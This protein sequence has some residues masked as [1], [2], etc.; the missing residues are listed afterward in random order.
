MA[1]P[2][3]LSPPSLYCGYDSKRCQQVEPQLAR[4]PAPKYTSPP[5]FLSFLLSAVIQLPVCTSTRLSACCR[6]QRQT[7]FIRSALA[8]P[9]WP[10]NI[11]YWSSG[12]F[13]NEI[14]FNDDWTTYVC[15]SLP[16]S[17]SVFACLS[18]SLAF[19]V[20]LSLFV[21]VS[22]VMGSDSVSVSGHVWPVHWTPYYWSIEK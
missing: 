11:I 20:V 17:L 3:H 21:C 14:L 8:S 12:I 5:L 22:I 15:S 6:G 1:D 16:L 10:G 7:I 18:L 4:S 9:S 2:I 13:Q 19:Y